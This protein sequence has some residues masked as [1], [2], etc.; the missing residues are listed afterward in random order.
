MD[1]KYAGNVKLEALM[2][3]LWGG[4]SSIPLVKP[5]QLNGFSWMVQNIFYCNFLHLQVIYKKTRIFFFFY[6]FIWL[7]HIAGLLLIRNSLLTF[8]CI[9][10]W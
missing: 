3:S 10:I 1:G 7:M 8:Y 4:F 2:G 6:T 5:G 9:F